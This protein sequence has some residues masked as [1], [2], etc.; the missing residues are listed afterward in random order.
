MVLALTATA[1]EP[2]REEI[3][4]R[5]GM[6]RT[7]LIVRDMDRPNIFLGVQFCRDE[8]HKLYQLL[9]QV[10]ALAERSLEARA[11]HG[12]MSKS[13]REEVQADFME[14]RVPLIVATS[15]FGMGVDRPDVRF[16]YHFDASGSL[17][18]YY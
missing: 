3:I 15:A 13:E 2:I 6:R 11:Y 4:E 8:G 17:D 18:A 16:V 12:G 14:G 1:A 7:K 5:L 10:E 9:E